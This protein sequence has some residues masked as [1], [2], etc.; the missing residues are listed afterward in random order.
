LNEKYVYVSGRNLMMQF[1]LP[2][3]FKNREYT[4]DVIKSLDEGRNFITSSTFQSFKPGIHTM[5]I[6]YLYLM[7]RNMQRPLFELWGLNWK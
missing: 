2:K 6:D 1:E 3:R 5:K 4:L 7:A